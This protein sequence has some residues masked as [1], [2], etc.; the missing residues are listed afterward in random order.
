MRVRR[1][2]AE[3]QLDVLGRMRAGADAD[4]EA[5]QFASFDDARQL[6]ARLGP[7]DRSRL[8]AQLGALLAEVEPVFGDGVSDAQL[9][10]Q[11]AWAI[12]RG[13]IAVARTPLFPLCSELPELLELPYQPDPVQNEI[14]DGFSLL[15]EAKIEPALA[16]EVQVEIEPPPTLEFNNNVE[17]APTL[18]HANNVEAPTPA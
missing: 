12:S 8:G 4:A 7:D 11:A 16:L 14:D 18:E 9:L 6:L 1:P 10:D 15:A 3:Y 13:L 17:P 2:F 5:L